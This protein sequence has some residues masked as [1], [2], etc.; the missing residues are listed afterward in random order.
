M[1][2]AAAAAVLLVVAGGLVAILSI[3]G[4]GS[5]PHLQTGPLIVKTTPK[6]AS[7]T[8]TV[9]ATPTPP[10]SG[11][12]SNAATLVSYAAGPVTV[13]RPANWKNEADA[14]PHDGYTESKWRS[15]LDSNTSVTIDWT[16][17]VQGSAA[18]NAE[19]VRAQ[20]SRTAGYREIGFQP[21]NLAG[22]QAQQWVF[23]VNGDRR[24]DYFINACG[25]GYAVLGSTSPASYERFNPTFRAVARSVAA[26][27]SNC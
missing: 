13:K 22:E 25:T 24:V 20:T 9:K 12:G 2:A 17:G 27:S 14:Q 16:P 26:R 4:S 8:V 6:P 23:E 7:K 18:S 11:G 1:I 19:G 21:T 3:S 5:A 15:P 10:S